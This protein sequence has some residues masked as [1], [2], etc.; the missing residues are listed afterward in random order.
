MH[1]FQE[2]VIV[3]AVRTPMGSFRGSL[4]AVPATKLGSV[5]IKGAID[6]AG[7]FGWFTLFRE[8][9]F[10]PFRAWC[11]PIS[12]SVSFEWWM[13]VYVSWV[14]L[15]FLCLGI[16]PEEVKEVYMGNVLQAGE[17]QAP[18]RQALL[19]A[20]MTTLVYS[21]FILYLHIGITPKHEFSESSTTLAVLTNQEWL[22]QLQRAGL[23]SFPLK[24]CL[25]AASVCMH[26]LSESHALY[27]RD[28]G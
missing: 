7:V 25:R 24:S 21:I 14:V 16:T 2:V 23:P 28:N 6:R 17:G 3:S 26:S 15:M 20:G 13:D 9:Y 22:N 27:M 5:A 12:H 18:T 1:G 10:P 4:A 11:A 8:D 19:G